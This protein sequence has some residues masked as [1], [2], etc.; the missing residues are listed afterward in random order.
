[1]FGWLINKIQK[2]AI[3]DI[4]GLI[5]AAIFKNIVKRDKFEQDGAKYLRYQA[6]ITALTDLRDAIN[7]HF[8]L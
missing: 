3:E 4:K 8:N 5:S 2:P 6:K 1:M 7:D